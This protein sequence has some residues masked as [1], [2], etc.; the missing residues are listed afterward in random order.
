MKKGDRLFKIHDRGVDT[1]EVV[2]IVAGEVLFE[3]TYFDYSTGK[4]KVSSY[5]TKWLQNGGEKFYDDNYLPINKAIE[6]AYK[7][8]ERRKT[9]RRV[10]DRREKPH[11]NL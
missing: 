11:D 7:Q 2:K 4:M 8:N 1:I 3:E 10:N 5:K 6:Q 9:E